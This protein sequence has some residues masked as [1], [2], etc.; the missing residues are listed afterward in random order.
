MTR[1]V[2]PGVTVAVH[3]TVHHATPNP[4][5]IQNLATTVFV[6]IS[7]HDMAL[8][9]P[10]LHVCSVKPLIVLLVLVFK[11]YVLGILHYIHAE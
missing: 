3:S 8:K 11:R 4:S 1:F 6:P 2:K 5:H 9:Q 10:E 7:I